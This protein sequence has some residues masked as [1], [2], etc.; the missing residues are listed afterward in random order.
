[1]RRSVGVGLEAPAGT[2]GSTPSSGGTS[3]HRAALPP[4]GFDRAF[5]QIPT[6]QFG[7]ILPHS[8]CTLTKARHAAGV[9]TA[10][11]APGATGTPFP[12]LTP[13]LA[14]CQSP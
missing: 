12:A 14:V 6:A 9:P 4:V 7:L 5:E 3:E 8:V 13:G 2:S 1:M 10:P 11:Q